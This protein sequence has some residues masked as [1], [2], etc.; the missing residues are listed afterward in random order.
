NRYSIDIGLKPVHKDSVLGSL[1]G[2]ENMVIFGVDEQPRK[3]YGLEPGPGA[4]VQVTASAIMHDLDEVVAIA[5]GESS[6]RNIP[7]SQYDVLHKKQRRSTI[8][9][10]SSRGLRLRATAG[11]L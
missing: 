3:A 4:G 2:R 7:Y 1:K 6:G 10:F 5:R 9:P 11:M 8:P